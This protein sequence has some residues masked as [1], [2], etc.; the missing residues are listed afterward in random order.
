[1]LEELRQSLK[2]RFSSLETFPVLQ[3]ATTIT[4]PREWPVEERA[5]AAFGR[6]E[7][8]TITTHFNVSLNMHITHKR[9]L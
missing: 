9:Y 8:T 4:D 3:A 6:R 7:L 2:T 1:M 5:L